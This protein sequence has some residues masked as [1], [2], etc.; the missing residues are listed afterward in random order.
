MTKV[1]ILINIE[2]ALLMMD[3]AIGVPLSMKLRLNKYKD[4]IG[5]VTSTYFKLLA[6]FF[7]RT[8]DT[9]A[10]EE[11]QMKLWEEEL[12]IDTEEIEVFIDNWKDKCEK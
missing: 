2:K 8:G 5:K 1:G 6:D 10:L 4:E 7:K 3:N 11:Y 12:E 9:K